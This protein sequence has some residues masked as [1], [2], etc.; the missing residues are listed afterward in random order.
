VLKQQS[1]ILQQMKQL[2]AAAVESVPVVDQ[3]ERVLVELESQLMQPL[4][5]VL[6]ASAIAIGHDNIHTAALHPVTGSP[7]PQPTTASS[8]LTPQRVAASPAKVPARSPP[9]QLSAAAGAALYHTVPLRAQNA[10][11]CKTHPKLLGAHG[12]EVC[13]FCSA[14]VTA[15]RR[16]KHTLAQAGMALQDFGGSEFELPVTRVEATEPRI[17]RAGERCARCGAER[18]GAGEQ[19]MCT[20]HKVWLFGQS[21][22]VPA[23]KWICHAAC[24]AECHPSV[25]GSAGDDAT[26]SRPESR[27]CTSH[28]RSVDNSPSQAAEFVGERCKLFQ[29]EEERAAG[30]PLLGGFKMHLA[31]LP[32]ERDDSPISHLDD[33]DHA[34]SGCST[35]VSSHEG[36]DEGKAAK[37]PVSSG[38]MQGYLLKKGGSRVVP[39]LTFDISKMSWSSVSKLFGRRNWKRRYFVLDGD[40]GKLSYYRSKLDKELLGCIDT[41][42]GCAAYKFTHHRRHNV[43]ALTCPN[44]DNFLIC[45]DTPYEMQV[46]SDA[47]SV[48]LANGVQGIA[49]TIMM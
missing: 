8:P 23:P 10:L 44:R 17:S 15:V 1:I 39:E 28:T 47:L 29:S 42:H 41:K 40:T 14:C 16:V 18:E 7:L 35:P 5:N 46:W 12:G 22:P 37:G 45:N 27:V 21:D 13:C 48:H 11:A 33:H 9:V 24:L 38:S 26:S 6:Q 36:A 3:H 19:G 20:L 43:L 32:E 31:E 4:Q 49:T 2:D 34:S 30:M 25:W